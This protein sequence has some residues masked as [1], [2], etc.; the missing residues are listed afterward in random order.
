MVRS[1]FA[2]IDKRITIIVTVTKIVF[3]HHKSE[4]AVIIAY[5]GIY[6]TC[7]DYN[8]TFNKPLLK[9]L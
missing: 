4:E 8:I 9:C 5:A 3:S 2:E 1:M 7:H 6:I